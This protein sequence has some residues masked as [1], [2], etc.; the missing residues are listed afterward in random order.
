RLTGREIEHAL[1]SGEHAQTLETYFGEAEY[2][3]LRQL[4]ARATRRDARARPRVLILP[5]ILG[6]MLARVK[7]S[8]SIDTIWIDFLDI[9][10]G[11]LTQLKLPDSAE[12]RAVDVHHAT[13]LKLKLWLQD[14]GFDA[15]FHPY[16]WRRGIPELGREL[17]ARVRADTASEVF[18]VAHSMGGLV[19]RAA[20]HHGMDKLKR[21]VML[22]TPNFGSFAPVMVFRGLYPFLNKVA[23]LDL[24]NSAQDLAGS[25]FS[26]HPG[27]TQMLPHRGRF[28]AIDLYDIHKWPAGGPRPQKSLL[29]GTLAAQQKLATA[30]DKYV[31]IAGV[32]KE[33]TV[34]LRVA[35]EEFVFERSRAGDGTVPLE[36]AVLPDVLT[37]YLAEEHGSLPKNVT[38][39]KAVADI[40][41]DGATSL[42]SERWQAT[43]ADAVVEVSESE[44]R[45]RF[46]AQASRTAHMSAS[47]LRNIIAELA[48]PTTPAPLAAEAGTAAAATLAP[49]AAFESLVIARRRQRRIDVRLARGSIT[50]VKTRAYVLGLFEGV[51]PAGAASAIDALMDGAISEF[52][53]RRMFSSAVGE[54]FVVPGGRSDVC[55]EFILFAGLGHFD[56]FNLKVLETV[57]ENVARTLAR[58]HVEE[59]VTVPIGAGTGLEIDQTLEAM[60]RG[61]FR[62]LEDTDREQAF[63][64]I[65]LCEIDEARYDALKWA[66]YRLSSTELCERVEVTLSELRLPPAPTARRAGKAALPASIYLTV[67]AARSGRNLSIESSLLTTG[68]KATVMSGRVTVP[69]AKL[70]EHL[71]LIETEKFTYAALT[72]FGEDLAALVLDG[73]IAAGVA[74]CAGQHMV[75][76]HDAEASRIPWETLCIGG[77]FPALAGGMSRRYLAANLSVAKWLEAQREDESLDLLLI[78]DPTQDLEGAR[79]EGERVYKLL[80]ERQRVRITRI[81]GASATRAR[82]R[83]EFGSARYDILH[84]A[85][86]AYFDPDQVARSGLLCADGPL[87]GAELA[88]LGNLPSLVFFNACESARVRRR[89]ARESGHVTRDLKERIERS[90][91]VAEAFLR[92]GVANYIG[93]Y[94]P[95]GD[96]AAK[97]FADRF[98]GALIAG[99]TLADAIGKGRADVNAIKSQDWADYI[100]YGSPDFRVKEVDSRDDRG[101]A[102]SA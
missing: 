26:T 100:F 69:E 101:A 38:V 59:F 70:R 14:Q 79:A 91:G 8:K 92:G 72:R 67:R 34:G 48:A 51:A 58:I 20:V 75:V 39:H 102:G 43:R 87:T 80:S 42:L 71:E 77:R 13:Y 24:K 17:A 57:A 68:A 23:A 12:I 2:A 60:L 22:G 82:L 94:W 53:Q 73:A 50:Q 28:S 93:T 32:D 18:I 7:G 78:V 85:G 45:A 9:L 65:T 49:T 27:L 86:H 63:R 29:S 52:R 19:A 40:L 15:E 61:F 30:P 74:G 76:V 99:E 4:A 37:Y 95:V 44:L 41:R 5:G 64:S 55:A 1:L 36:L 46:E 16:D 81:E 11:R 66:M 62:G 54:I 98:Y 35:D 89:V 3:E 31:M 83:T 25:V 88:E 96:A 10:L 6:S 97:T 21:L 84:Y 47:D 56:A 90:V 33:S